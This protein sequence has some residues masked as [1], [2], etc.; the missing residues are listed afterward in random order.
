MA[1]SS[2]DGIDLY[3]FPRNTS[4]N[5]TIIDTFRLR[6][7]PEQMD[8]IKADLLGQL[9]LAKAPF[10]DRRVACIL[11]GE[12]EGYGGHTL[13]LERSDFEDPFLMAL[14]KIPNQN[15]RIYGVMV[16]GEGPMKEKHVLPSPAVYDRIASHLLPRSPIIVIPPNQT[17]HCRVIPESMHCQ[18]YRSK[19]PVV[20]RGN[21]IIESTIE[22]I[23]NTLL[24]MQDCEFVACLRHAGIKDKIE[25]YITGSSS[26]HSGP[27]YALR[28]GLYS[29]LDIIAVGK[30]SKD[31][32]VERF[33]A[34][35]SSFYGSLKKESKS[36]RVDGVGE[37]IEGLLYTG[38]EESISIDFFPQNKVENA[39]VRSEY[40]SRNFFC[41]LS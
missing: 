3:R 35:A 10:S 18:A 22:A 37:V 17:K 2:I 28:P 9:A 4:E 5:V 12:D 29:D 30:F 27:S 13:E 20:F 33:E 38:T 39:F 40:L 21:S 26:G 16:T 25:Y 14:S 34:I 1:F 31:Y 8:D 23:E 11:A 36:P 6:P 19:P 15:T 7:I 24:S 41:K 32:I